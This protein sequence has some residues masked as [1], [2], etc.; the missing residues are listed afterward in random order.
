VTSYDSY[1]KLADWDGTNAM[2]IDWTGAMVGMAP[3]IGQITKYL[4]LKVL[5]IE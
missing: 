4:G 2:A 3:R 1:N 5:R